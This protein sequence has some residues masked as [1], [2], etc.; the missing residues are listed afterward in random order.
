MT[1]KMTNILSGQI[2]EDNTRLTM[3]ELCDACS[4]RAE[5]IIALVDEGF[6]EPVGVE[7][8]HWC[9]DGASISRIRRAIRLERDLGVNLA[10]VSLAIE[11]LEEIERLRAQLDSL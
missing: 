2:I 3:R 11:L 7:R 8:S 9:F 4:V 10:G 5:Y 6:I 1:K